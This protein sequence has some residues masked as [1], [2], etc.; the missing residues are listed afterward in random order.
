MKLKKSISLLLTIMIMLSCK[1]SELKTDTG[2]LAEELKGSVW[3]G[4][5][6][7]T[8]GLNPELQPFSAML[9]NDGTLT[10]SDL[11]NTRAAGTW[12]INGNKINLE[13]PD[14]TTN[15]ADIT[16]EQWSNFSNPEA[17]GFEIVNISRS[18]IPTL[19]FL[20]QTKWAGHLINSLFGSYDGALY[21]GSGETV[22][23]TSNGY[24]TDEAYTVEG[25]G[26]RISNYGYFIFLNNSMNVKGYNH[27]SN[28]DVIW[29]LTKQ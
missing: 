21:F 8:V 1:K 12:S 9:N 25:A 23:V 10:W 26:I 27:Y 7:Y 16:K 28:I 14:G 6:K 18:A 11:Q 29:N 17:N 20:Q 3:A 24:P 13:F 5:F 4:E 22:T 15:S 19:A 2:N